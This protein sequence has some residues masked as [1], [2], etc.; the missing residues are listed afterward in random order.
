MEAGAGAID[1]RVKTLERDATS[2][3]KSIGDLR[4]KTAQHDTALAVQASQLH[5]QEHDIAQLDD[6]VRDFEKTLQ[7]GLKEVKDE[8][9][10][11]LSSTRKYLM[12]A[13]ITFSGMMLMGL[14]YI[15]QV[16]LSKGG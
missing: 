11:E 15:L 5:E 1:F 6:R 9:S 16:L 2:H 8:V 10:E 13:V 12:G 14:G 7:A 4:G 3:H